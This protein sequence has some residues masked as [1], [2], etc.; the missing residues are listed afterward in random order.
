MKV[1][2]VSSE[3]IYAK[4]SSE[5]SRRCLAD[6]MTA[7]DKVLGN[8]EWAAETTKKVIFKIWGKKLEDKKGINIWEIRIYKGESKRNCQ[9]KKK[10]NM[11]WLQCIVQTLCNTDCVA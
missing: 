6:Q 4:L 7:V 9:M 2:W 1:C 10:T 8:T 11:K 5:K 3:K